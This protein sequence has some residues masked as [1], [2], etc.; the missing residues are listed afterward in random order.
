MTELCIECRKNP[1]EGPKDIEFVYQGLK[2]KVSK[3]RLKCAECATKMIIEYFDHYG[4]MVVGLEGGKIKINWPRY[5][6]LAYQCTS[7]QAEK[8]HDV[9]IAL[10]IFSF[11]REENWK[12]IMPQT[13]SCLNL[14]YKVFGYLYFTREEDAIEFGKLRSRGATFKIRKYFKGRYFENIIGDKKRGGGRPNAAF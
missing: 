8:M 9:L 5:I 6:E 1:P 14:Y 4:K 3:G 13:D 10:G 7:E 11:N 2:F 12:I